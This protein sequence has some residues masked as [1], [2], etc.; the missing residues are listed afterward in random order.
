M[1]NPGVLVAGVSPGDR[2]DLVIRSILLK[3]SNDCTPAHAYAS[4]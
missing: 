1:L 3:K 2:V 4:G